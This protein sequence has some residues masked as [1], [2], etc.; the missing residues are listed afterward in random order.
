ML[1]VYAHAASLNGTPYMVTT[2]SNDA[3]VKHEE[4]VLSLH[5]NP[6]TGEGIWTVTH[7]EREECGVFRIDEHGVLSDPAI[8]KEIDQAAI[9]W[10][11]FLG[12]GKVIA[13]ESTTPLAPTV[14]L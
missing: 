11:G 13:E 6:D 5:F 3:S 1:N 8:P 2:C 14:H 10:I 7:P 4:S 12:R 9:D